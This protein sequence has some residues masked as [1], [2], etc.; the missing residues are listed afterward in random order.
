MNAQAAAS[1]LSARA[2]EEPV[3]PIPGRDGNCR[4]EPCWVDLIAYAERCQFCISWWSKQ[5]IHIHCLS[6]DR[7]R[8]RDKQ[9]SQHRFYPPQSG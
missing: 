8:P 9:W 2:G 7:A 3:C 6:L 4:W 5:D 1:M